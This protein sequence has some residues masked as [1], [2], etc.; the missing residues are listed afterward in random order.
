M[1]HQGGLFCV[2]TQRQRGACHRRR[3]DGGT[4]SAKGELKFCTVALKVE[5]GS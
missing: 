4:T 2:Y 1:D 3:E 5:E